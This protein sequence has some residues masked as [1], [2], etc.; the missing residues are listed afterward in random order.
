MTTE[1]SLLSSGQGQVARK[2]RF[3]PLMVK[4][5]GEIKE[6]QQGIGKETKGLK[7]TLRRFSALVSVSLERS[8]ET[9]DTMRAR[10]FKKG[11]RHYSPYRFKAADGVFLFLF[12]VLFVFQIAAFA[13]GAFAAGARI[14]GAD[15]RQI[16]SG[17]LDAP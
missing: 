4:T 16:W 3:L 17:A 6:A 11:R 14:L 12:T 13:R 8:I 2:L 5:A 15:F 10:G 7:N 1:A 9:A